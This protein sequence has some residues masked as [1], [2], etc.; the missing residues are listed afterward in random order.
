MRKLRERLGIKKGDMRKNKMKR[1]TF[2]EVM[3][4]MHKELTKQYK[5]G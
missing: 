5:N 4:N 2:N 1:P 3:E